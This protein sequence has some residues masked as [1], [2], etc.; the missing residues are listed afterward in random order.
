MT[1]QH[2]L[3]PRVRAVQLYELVSNAGK[4]RQLVKVEVEQLAPP[5]PAV[6]RV[7]TQDVVRLNLIPGLNVLHLTADTV[8]APTRHA[9][10]C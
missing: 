3:R 9:L 1:Y 6:I 10:C 2:S 8:S 7:G 5:A 4:T